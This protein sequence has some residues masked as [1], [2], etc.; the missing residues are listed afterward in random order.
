M[1]LGAGLSSCT[2]PTETV[3]L[4][5]LHPAL[6]SSKQT[7]GRTLLHLEGGVM[8]SQGGVEKISSKYSKNEL[9][10]EIELGLKDDLSPEIDF[11]TLIPDSV[12]RVV[13]GRERIPI[14]D[15]AHGPLV[16]PTRVK[17]SRSL[18]PGWPADLQIQSYDW[19]AWNRRVDQAQL[20]Q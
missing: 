1:A 20:G 18:P 15:R 7:G 12:D 9:T 13:F 19:D 8:I 4:R 2:L 14:W 17:A 5:Q 3:E 10:L 6:V 16:K 11:Q